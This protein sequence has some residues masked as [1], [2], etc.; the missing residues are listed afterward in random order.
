MLNAIYLLAR[1]SDSQSDPALTTQIYRDLEKHVQ[2]LTAQPNLLAKPSQRNIYLTNFL[3]SLDHIKRTKVLSSAFNHFLSAPNYS[4]ALLRLTLHLS[5]MHAAVNN[6][7]GDLE[8]ALGLIGNILKVTKIQPKNAREFIF[9]TLKELGVGDLK[10]IDSSTLASNFVSKNKKKGAATSSMFSQ[11]LH[12]P[13]CQKIYYSNVLSTPTCYT[14]YH[15]LFNS[16]YST[17]QTGLGDQ[18][19]Y[20]FQR[21]KP[22]DLLQEGLNRTLYEKELRTF[23]DLTVRDKN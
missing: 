4:Q 21:Y 7:R 9:P 8:T 15:M 10:S 11:L 22:G 18:A 19:P 23:L 12:N 5:A 17:L 16:P 3:D 2:Y 6:N 20:D 14:N 1:M 13:D